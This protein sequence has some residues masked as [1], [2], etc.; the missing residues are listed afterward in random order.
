M[1]VK[2][3]HYD[4]IVK[5]IITEKATLVSDANAYV[6]EV[7]KDS[8]K[9]AIKQ[10][11]EALFNVKVKAVNTTITKGKTK[12]FR[13]RPGVRSDVKKAYV[14]LEAGNSIDVSTGL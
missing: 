12:R 2:P 1:S 11:V 6:F 10:A 5:P 14:T 7:A 13:G 3:E 9:P 8:S 4:V